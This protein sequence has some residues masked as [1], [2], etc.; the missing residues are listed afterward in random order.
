MHHLAQAE[1][2]EN[3]DS[4]TPCFETKGD[5]LEVI[6]GEKR[7]RTQAMQPP[8]VSHKWR[9]EHPMC[10]FKKDSSGRSTPMIVRGRQDVSKMFQ[11]IH[12]RMSSRER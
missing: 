11:T 4:P 8:V 3:E 2:K 5:I 10:G 12:Q 6:R 9:G 1:T 7:C